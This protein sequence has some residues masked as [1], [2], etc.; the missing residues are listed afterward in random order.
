MFKT[1]SYRHILAQLS[2][3]EASLL[4]RSKRFSIPFARITPSIDQLIK[5]CSQEVVKESGFT[6]S[7]TKLV[8][9]LCTDFIN[10]TTYS[11]NGTSI[12]IGKLMDQY[13]IESHELLYAIYNKMYSDD[14]TTNHETMS[15]NDAKLILRQSHHCIEYLRGKPIKIFFRRERG[16]GQYI[17]MKR[18]ESH[19]RVCDDKFYRAIMWLMIHKSNP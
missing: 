2:G 14:L 13:G 18:S 10:N 1:I 5:R 19:M 8:D 17:L 15:M 12:E 7:N 6:H 11:H 4:S 16:E 3:W 9:K